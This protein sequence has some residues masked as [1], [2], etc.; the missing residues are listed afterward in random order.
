MVLYPN[1]LPESERV[2]SGICNRKLA[3]MYKNN[4]S[5][6]NM[7]SP[8]DFTIVEKFKFHFDKK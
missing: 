7:I 2:C 4:K 8:T 3:Y 5:I 1:K 6:I